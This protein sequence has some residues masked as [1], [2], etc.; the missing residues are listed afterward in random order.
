MADCHDVGADASPGQPEP[1]GARWAVPG[2]AVGSFPGAQLAAGALGQAAQ[3][4]TGDVPAV[5]E[6]A[7]DRAVGEDP[8]REGGPLG[9]E[10]RR[11]AGRYL[12]HDA[13]YAVRLLAG[14]AAVRSRG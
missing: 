10:P 7:C 9:T 11:L 5:L 14:A 6:A 2:V 3:G 4:S 1:S 8:G 13:P 12:R